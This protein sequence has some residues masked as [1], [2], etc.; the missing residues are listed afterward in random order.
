[1][2]T[3]PRLADNED[4]DEDEE[5]HESWRH[6]RGKEPSPFTRSTHTSKTDEGMLIDLKVRLSDYPTFDGNHEKRYVVKED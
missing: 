4:P 3:N 6:V 5:E 2:E 1:M